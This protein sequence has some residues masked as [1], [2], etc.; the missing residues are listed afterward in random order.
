MDNIDSNISVGKSFLGRGWKFPV[1]FVDNSFTVELVEDELD[2][3]ESIQIILNT[4]LGERVMHPDFGANLEDLL[5]EKIDITTLTMITNRLKRAFLYHESRVRIDEIN[6]TPDIE[7][8][9]IQV[10]VNYTVS[11]T[12]TRTNLVYPYYINEGTDI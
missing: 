2:I 4:T 11:A 8:G 10:T 6:L 7:N 1:T 3:A 12:N 5:F 9:I